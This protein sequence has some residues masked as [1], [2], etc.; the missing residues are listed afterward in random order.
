MNEIDRT[1]INF[2]YKDVKEILE[3]KQI[4]EEIK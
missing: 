1:E 2:D 4:F 3:F